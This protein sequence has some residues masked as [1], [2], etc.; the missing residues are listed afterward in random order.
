[1]PYHFLQS[2]TFWMLVGT[3]WSY[4]RDSFVMHAVHKFWNAMSQLVNI[5]MI[6]KC[7]IFFISKCTFSLLCINNLIFNRKRGR[8]T[9]TF[10]TLNVTRLKSRLFIWIESWDF[11]ALRRSPAGRS[12]TLRTFATL[13]RPTWCQFFQRSTSSF[14][15]ATISKA[16]KRQSSCQFFCAFGICAH[17]S[18]L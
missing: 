14:L 18:S 6:C 5:K 7:T 15:Q 2:V 12:I 13:P 8:I 1:M 3:V 11:V 4:Q 10:P 17:K 16:Q 9:F